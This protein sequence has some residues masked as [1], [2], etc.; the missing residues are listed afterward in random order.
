MEITGNKTQWPGSGFFAL[1]MLLIQQSPATD[2]N[3]LNMHITFCDHINIWFR[4]GHRLIFVD[5]CGW[6]I[7]I[8]LYL[9][10]AKRL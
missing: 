3:L 5:A 2:K 10:R 9:K 6:L 1:Y 7:T 8:L 4:N